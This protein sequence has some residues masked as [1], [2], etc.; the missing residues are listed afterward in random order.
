MFETKLVLTKT[1]SKDKI[2]SSF[3]FHLVGVQRLVPHSLQTFLR[4]FTT[5][6]KNLSRKFYKHILPSL[7]QVIVNG[8]H[9]IL[10]HSRFPPTPSSSSA[11][12]IYEGPDS[13]FCHGFAVIPFRLS[14]PLISV[15]I[16]V[17]GFYRTQPNPKFFRIVK[18]TNRGHLII[19][20]AVTGHSSPL[21]VS[22]FQ[23]Y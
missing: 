6:Y 22:D 1:K 12:P 2:I 20:E 23:T 3:Q 14:L 19:W 5:T 16:A 11:S 7:V 13:F 21:A 15:G 4:W 18:Q 10:S 8:I 17:F 9:N